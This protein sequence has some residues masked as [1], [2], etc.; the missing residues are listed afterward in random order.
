[1][2]WLQERQEADEEAAAAKAIEVTAISNK[3]DDKPKYRLPRGWKVRE[4]PPSLKPPPS[5]QP[6]SYTYSGFWG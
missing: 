3:K 2:K 1:M 5:S 4:L 6:Y